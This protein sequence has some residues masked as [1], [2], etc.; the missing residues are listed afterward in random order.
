ME[1]EPGGVVVL[2]WAVF[3]PFSWL[4]IPD[5][6]EASAFFSPV[7]AADAAS[8]DTDDDSADVV[9]GSAWISAVLVKSSGRLSEKSMSILGSGRL[10][11]SLYDW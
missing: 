9:S 1:D 5:S 10:V 8:G 11:N 7:L 2:V 4:L 6:A 3:S